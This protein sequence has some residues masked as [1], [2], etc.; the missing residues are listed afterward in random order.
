MDSESKD[1]TLNF[2]ESYVLYGIVRDH[3]DELSEM[4]DDPDLQDRELTQ[5]EWKICNSLA[6]KLRQILK[7]SGYKFGPEQ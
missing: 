1:V 3:R 2:K 7:D 4:L 6:R 5:E